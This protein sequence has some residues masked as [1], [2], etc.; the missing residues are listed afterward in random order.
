M[1]RTPKHRQD[2]VPKKNQG[3]TVLLCTY[4]CRP[5]SRTTRTGVVFP[6]G[7]CLQEVER[8]PLDVEAAGILRT[9][10]DSARTDDHFPV[11]TA[12][13]PRVAVK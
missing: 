13:W 10:L 9:V 5:A 7:G 12:T 4:L 8:Q 3:H 11:R 1:E 6:K 2:Q